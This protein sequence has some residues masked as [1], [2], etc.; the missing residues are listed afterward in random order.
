MSTMSLVARRVRHGQVS[1]ALALLSDRQL[2]ERL[3]SASRLGSGIGGTTWLLDV[4]GVAVFVKRV[5]LTDLELRAE[6][7]RS[8]A[9]VFELP[10][11]AGYGVG[12]AGGGAWRELAAHV[13]TSD[14]ALTGQCENFPLLHHWRVCTR[15]PHPTP[16]RA[17]LERKVAFWHDDPAVRARLEALAD[18]SADLA[19]F[20]EYIP[21]DL[22]TWLGADSPDAAYAMAER[23]LRAVTGFLGNAGFQHFDTHFANILTDGERLYLTDVDLALSPRFYLTDTEA[24]FLR[25][26]A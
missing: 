3:N 10:P 9:N 22:H 19:L 14:W 5:A 24:R 7:L 20:L 1:T 16:D 8:T 6:N 15:P 26:H 17:E 2:T 18:S 21:H 4:D 12:S 25:E 23:D 11:W 13:M